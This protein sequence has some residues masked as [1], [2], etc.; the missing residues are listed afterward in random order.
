MD[1]TIDVDDAGSKLNTNYEFFELC[2][3]GRFAAQRFLEAH[4]QYI[5]RRSTIDLHAARPA[6][7]A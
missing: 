4:F 6:A 3:R 2:A 7:V 5:G 1:D